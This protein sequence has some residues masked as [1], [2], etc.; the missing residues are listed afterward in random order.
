MNIKSLLLL[1]SSISLLAGCSKSVDTSTSKTNTNSTETSFPSSEEST[2]IDESITYTT[3]S[4][5]IETNNFQGGNQFDNMSDGAIKLKNALDPDAKII[6]SVETSNITIQEHA[7]IEG[8]NA[9]DLTIGTAKYAGSLTINT[10]SP[11]KAI[12]FSL[13]AYTKYVAYNATNNIDNSKFVVNEFDE[14]VLEPGTETSSAPIKDY[15]YS[16]ESV[17]SK[18]IIKNFEAN[19]RIFIKSIAFTY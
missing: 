12:T 13:Q 8:G 18:I 14:V 3:P 17:T 16:F 2:V 10:L 11:L 9:L 19:Q 6:S 1:V 4:D 5:F 15:T 7:L